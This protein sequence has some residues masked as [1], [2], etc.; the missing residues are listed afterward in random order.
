MKPNLSITQIQL[1]L[2]AHQKHLRHDDSIPP[3]S[4]IADRVGISR[5]TL[6]AIING[7][8]SEFGQVA[9][10]RLGKVISQ[11]S[12]KPSYQRSNMA[13]VDLT[14]VT[15]RIKFGVSS[16]YSNNTDGCH[17]WSFNNCICNF[18]KG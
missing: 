18:P 5:Q 13:R 14:G 12:S 8:R 11:I 16:F 1:W 10:I 3:I 17:Y 2:K 7:E 15:P 9:Q 4:A 6:Y